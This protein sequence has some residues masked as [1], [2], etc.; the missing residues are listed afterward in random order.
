MRLIFDRARRISLPWWLFIAGAPLVVFSM[1]DTVR[2]ACFAA[3]IILVA[4]AAGVGFG[5]SL[6]ER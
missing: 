4:A 5:R 1:A 2:D 3:G 6:D